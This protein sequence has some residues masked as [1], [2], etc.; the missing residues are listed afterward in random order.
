M[1][2]IRKR[3]AFQFEHVFDAPLSQYW[4][5]NL[6]GFQIT[7]FMTQVLEYE[8]QNVYSAVEHTYGRD[9]L[10]ILGKIMNEITDWCTVPF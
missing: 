8:G 6:G 5:D 3:N 7:P 9:G 10:I 1:K 2:D 4:D